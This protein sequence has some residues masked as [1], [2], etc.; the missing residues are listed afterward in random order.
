MNP[1]PK[2][3]LPQPN[4]TFSI[5][6]KLE[7]ER[8]KPG[9]YQGRLLYWMGSL[10]KMIK[11]RKERISEVERE[12]TKLEN[13]I[14]KLR[15]EILNKTEYQNELKQHL[16]GLDKELEMYK[17]FIKDKESEGSLDK[18]PSFYI[19]IQKKPDGNQYYVGRVRY[20]QRKN[21]KRREK[22]VYFG[23]VHILNLKYGKGFEKG[24]V[25]KKVKGILKDELKK[26]FEGRY[27]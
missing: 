11:V 6:E 22:W 8:G 25:E 4:L 3:K 23:S 15:D 21:R 1:K 13:D 19:K 26:M 14:R 2:R 5:K 17:D 9:L 7:S 20:F 16:I 24:Q 12:K 18:K 10:K 27:F